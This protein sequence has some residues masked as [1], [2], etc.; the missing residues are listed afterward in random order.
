VG[1]NP[2]ALKKLQPRLIWLSTVSG[3]MT[4]GIL[5]RWLLTARRYCTLP[6][7]I[8]TNNSFIVAS[9]VLCQRR[10]LAWLKVRDARPLLSTK[11]ILSSMGEVSTLSQ[12][13]QGGNSQSIAVVAHTTG[14]DE[15]R[16]GYREQ[17][18]CV[19]NTHMSDV[20]LSLHVS[21]EAVLLS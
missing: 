20:Q 7:L 12:H 13:V 4:L 19:A 18:G 17:R 2:L 3:R 21:R 16:R 15:L 10:V 11:H 5:F 14:T 8:T 9:L 6:L 1:W